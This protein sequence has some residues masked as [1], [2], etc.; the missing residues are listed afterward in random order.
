MFLVHRGDQKKALD[1]P[2][3]PGLELQTVVNC[4]VGAGTLTLEQL[5]CLATALLSLASGV[6]AS[7]LTSYVLSVLEP[8]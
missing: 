3:P 5:G 8:G 2:P 7:M 1:L 6:Y 4:L